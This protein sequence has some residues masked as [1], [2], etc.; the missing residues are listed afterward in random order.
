M[1]TLRNNVNQ[2]MSQMNYLRLQLRNLDKIGKRQF[3]SSNGVNLFPQPEQYMSLEEKLNNRQYQQDLAYK[4]ASILFDKDSNRINVFLQTLNADG[5]IYFN[6]KFPTFQQDLK[7]G[8][9]FIGVNQALKYLE[10]VEELD[11]LTGG[12]SI[13]LEREEF[14]SGVNALLDN[15]STVLSTMDTSTYNDSNNPS[16]IDYGSA[17]AK[18][19]DSTNNSNNPS[20]IDYGNIDDDTN[21]TFTHDQSNSSVASSTV[22]NPDM[23]NTDDIIT[24]D[25]FDTSNQKSSSSNDPNDP[26]PLDDASL[27][28]HDNQLDDSVVEESKGEDNVT[29]DNYIAPIQTGTKYIERT[30]IKLR[31]S[32][33][34][35][36]LK[37]AVINY[38][39]NNDRTANLVINNRRVDM[40]IKNTVLEGMITNLISHVK[41]LKTSNNELYNAICTGLGGIIQSSQ[42]KKTQEWIRTKQ[43][44][45]GSQWGFGMSHKNV[46]P[47]A[48]GL[49]KKPNINNTKLL[50]TLNKI[51]F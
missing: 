46:Q 1:T 13:P 21:T 27:G 38:I 24:A 19:D 7:K 12:V 43:M 49:F 35:K 32:L 5:I 8:N 41:T 16:N 48:N 37:I 29:K 40:S 25:V 6:Q 26:L 23:N 22:T 33:L 9:A 47:S 31:S 14:I 2:K 44:G 4:N 15:N 28:S 3:D 51:N 20:N 45:E 34:N 30:G 18:S 50:N 36:D 11:D 10:R 42:N 17:E 39:V